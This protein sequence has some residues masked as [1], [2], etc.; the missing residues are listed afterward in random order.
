[1]SVDAWYRCI[2]ACALGND[3]I[4]IQLPFQHSVFLTGTYFPMGSVHA[5][6]L[7]VPA[8]LL[9]PPFYRPVLFN[10][11]AT[12]S[13]VPGPRDYGALGGLMGHEV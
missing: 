4:F 9:Q 5:N 1:M 10:S 12:S 8:A 13:P 11:G 2:P 7:F 6:A 3:L